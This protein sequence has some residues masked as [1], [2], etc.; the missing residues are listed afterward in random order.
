[1]NAN[2]PTAPITAAELA[3]REFARLFPTPNALAALAH[4]ESGRLP[5]E[6]VEALFAKALAAG[7]ADRDKS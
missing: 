6:A 2:I 3:V 5:W 4:C 7:I 1:M